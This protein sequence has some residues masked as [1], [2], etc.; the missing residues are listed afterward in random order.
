MKRYAIPFLFMPFIT[1]AHEDHHIG[2]WN[3]DPF[4]LISLLLIT[5]FYMTGLRNLKKIKSFSLLSFAGSIFFLLLALF[6]PVDFWSDELQTWHMIQHMIIMV[7]AAPLFILGRPMFVLLWSLPSSIRR[8]LGS[9]YGWLMGRGIGHYIFWHPLILWLF[10]GFTLWIWHLPS[11]YEAA[12]LNQ[13]LH[14]FQHISFFVSS[15][16]FWRILIDPISRYRPK[17]GLAIFYIFATTLHASLLGL[18]LA[19]SQGTW[20]KY[21]LNKTAT[22]GLTPLEDQ[23]VAGLIMW[24]PGCMIYVIAAALIFHQWLKKNQTE[25]Q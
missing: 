21:Y 15:V 11:L 24:M 25:E 23:Q 13:R 9:L 2:K 8:K 17:K 18:F 1:F 20:Y 12:L 3:F 7:I 6:S 19:L 16:F 14:D 22:W 4:L 10:F 5:V